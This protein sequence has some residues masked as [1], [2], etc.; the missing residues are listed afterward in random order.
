M[1]EPKHGFTSDGTPVHG[2]THDHLKSE[3]RYQ[4]FCK[5]LAVAITSRVGTMTC[6]FVFAFIS[7]CSLPAILYTVNK[8]LFGFFPHWMVSASLVAVV[9]WIA[10]YVLQLVLLPIIIVGQNVQSEASDARAAKTFDDTEYIK[11]QVNENTDGGVKLILDRLD[12]IHD[13]L[14]K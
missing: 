5:S 3:T 8:S 9:A 6:A 11:N 14:D 1:T 2:K 13:R 4:R 12:T 10:S 7:L